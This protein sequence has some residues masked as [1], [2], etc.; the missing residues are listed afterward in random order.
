MHDPLSFN[1]RSVAKLCF[2]AAIR[3]SGSNRCPT[4]SEPLLPMRLPSR[5]SIGLPRFESTASSLV[6]AAQH[7]VW[8]ALLQSAFALFLL[9]LFAWLLRF[10]LGTSRGFFLLPFS[11]FF[12]PALPWNHR[13]HPHSL[14]CE[15]PIESPLLSFQAGEV[16]EWRRPHLETRPLFHG[17]HLIEPSLQVGRQIH[18]AL[19]AQAHPVKHGGRT[20]IGKQLYRKRPHRIQIWA[21]R[22]FPLICSGLDIQV[23]PLPSCARAYGFE[24][25]PP[26][27]I[28]EHHLPITKQNV[29][30]LNVTMYHRW[31][32]RMQIRKHT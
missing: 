11:S 2:I 6:Y 10:Q 29:A 3:S 31:S 5:Q 28:N 15:L 30:R 20:S 24:H 9:Q 26:V 4:T 22:G 12:W 14:A 13:T 18:D 1:R 23:S 17:Q 25:S 21:N 32:K 27:K 8:R 7:L 19:P 16:H